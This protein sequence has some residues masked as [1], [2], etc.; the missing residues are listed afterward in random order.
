MTKKKSLITIIILSIIIAALL[1]SG[2]DT[3]IFTVT[4]NLYDD[5]IETQSV[6]GG[7]LSHIKVPQREGYT[8]EGW[9]Y[10][11]EFNSPYKDGDSI[12]SDITLYAKWSLGEVTV[13]YHLDS[14]NTVQ[15]TTAIGENLI[16]TPQ[17]TGFV[18]DGWYTDANLTIPYDTDKVTKSMD[19]YAKWEKMVTYKL[20]INGEFFK[21]GYS[22]VGTSIDIGDT[23]TFI[24]V[25]NKWYKDESCTEIFDINYVFTDTDTI[26]EF[27]IYAYAKSTNVQVY[28]S[29]DN[30]EY[31]SVTGTGKYSTGDSVT[32]TATIRPQS[33]TE[34]DGEVRF[35]GWYIGDNLV[36]TS[37]SYTFEV[38]INSISLIAKF[39][40]F[41]AY[42]ISVKS[43]DIT[44]GTVTGGGRY[45][46][47]DKVILVATP[48]D[49]MSFVGWYIGDTLVSNDTEYTFTANH[50][51]VYI[52]KFSPSETTLVFD[53]DG[54][55]SN[56]EKHLHGSVGDTIDLSVYTPAKEG[57]TFG[58]WKNNEQIVE[59]LVLSTSNKVTAHWIYGSEG[60]N[61]NTI[62]G[63]VTAVSY[64]GNDLYVKIPK[65]NAN[66][67]T[68]TTIGTRVFDNRIDEVFGFEIPE[69]ITTIKSYAFSS[70][71]TTA[72]S[73]T[74]YLGLSSL[75]YI[76]IPATV[77][78]IESNAFHGCTS[79]SMLEFGGDIEN[80]STMVLSYTPYSS[81]II[82]A[83]PASNIVDKIA[84][85]NDL[86][87]SKIRVNVSLVDKTNQAIVE[88]AG[89]HATNTSKSNR[90][91]YIDQLPAYPNT[92]RS[93][94]ALMYAV[95][96]GYLPTMFEE[97][98]DAY[99]VWIKSR[100]I[101]STII[102]DDMTDFE[103]THMI[104]DYIISTVTYDDAMLELK[105]L[106][107]T[108]LY[109][110]HFLEGAI[111]DQVAVC[112][113]YSKAF[114][115]LCSIEGIDVITVYGKTGK[116]GHAWNKVYVDSDW[117]F[118]DATWGDRSLSGENYNLLVHNY[119]LIG[120]QSDHVGYG[121]SPQCVDYD[122]YSSSSYT[123]SQGKTFDLNI[124]SAEELINCLNY[125]I[126]NW[127]KM[128]TLEIKLTGITYVT[129]LAKMKSF[130]L[131]VSNYYALEDNI[132]IFMFS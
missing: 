71:Q 72:N 44:M 79:L 92:I 131:N 128:N 73:T 24:V 68:V 69:T 57:Y 122:Y 56:F 99:K 66:G 129:A 80:F 49:S 100:E 119:F 62:N 43:N 36:S 90:Y 64:T 14:I 126:E 5:V 115:L 55:E 28:V 105:E 38:N 25:D 13:T 10:D 20:F 12:N 42:A 108:A 132:Y 106:S 87:E 18:F 95:Q 48:S 98:S 15:Q 118:V 103:K 84:R 78:V 59:K 61:F 50:S 77:T 29:S 70:S 9:F 33:N 11:S 109:R 2:C 74:T 51:G 65:T 19:L 117:R 45:F 81:M 27:N 82:Y 123:T 37:L 30:Y 94:A 41:N 32:V 91:F 63:Q 1:L 116:T 67:E 101:L 52:A 114:E 112:D 124:N 22:R 60:F 102:T 93:T 46:Q 47:N 96:Q 21:K 75:S 111:L 35:L 125:Y 83:P 107:S 34:L 7:T 121:D 130:G 17:L 88:N 89:S 39:D 86:Y 120:E 3:F 23:D 53:L 104:Y 16:E 40:W 113:G 6:F 76:Y 97:D 26:N 127:S 8:F 58:G 54:G 110:A 31:G 85:H 4:L